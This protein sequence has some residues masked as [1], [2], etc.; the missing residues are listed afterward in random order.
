MKLELFAQNSSNIFA[1]NRLL[2]LVLLVIAGVTLFNSYQI[3]RAVKTTHTIIIPANMQTQIEF[4]E[5]KPTDE[6][7]ENIA[8]LVATLGLSYSPATAR[9]QFD[10]MLKYYAPQDY[11]GGFD[12][13]YTLASRIEEARVSQAFYLKKLDLKADNQIELFGDKVMYSD[14]KMLS[15]ETNTSFIIKYQINNGLFQINSFMAK[16]DK[17]ESSD[18]KIENPAHN[19]VEPAKQK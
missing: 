14:S 6:Y 17:S 9:I 10:K 13:W 11:A 4:I 16:G 19:S 1:E 12:M 5:G 2:K 18:K 3:Q 15:T 8:R 7:V